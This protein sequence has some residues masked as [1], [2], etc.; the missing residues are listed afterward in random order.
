M[1]A[2]KLSKISDKE[3]WVRNVFCWYSALL[4]HGQHDVLLNVGWKAENKTMIHWLLSIKSDEQ[5]R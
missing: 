3:L 5:E 1:G 2:A 4:E